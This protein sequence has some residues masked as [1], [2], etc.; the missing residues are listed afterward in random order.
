MQVTAV[1]ARSRWATRAV[2]G[3]RGRDCSAST[4]FSITTSG[5]Q[6]LHMVAI[7]FYEEAF[8]TRRDEYLYV[9]LNDAVT[10]IGENRETSHAWELNNGAK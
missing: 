2:A 9:H 5:F 8:E 1:V 10:K 3:T 7:P 4:A 6:L